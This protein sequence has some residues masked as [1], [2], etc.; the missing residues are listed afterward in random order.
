MAQI[1]VGP[2]SQCPVPIG[3]QVVPEVFGGKHTLF[4]GKPVFAL[5][6]DSHTGFQICFFFFGLF[7]YNVD[8]TRH[9]TRTI[10]NGTRALN[11]LDTFNTVQ[12]DL[13]YIRNPKRG[14]INIYTIHTNLGCVAGH[15]PDV[16]FLS[17]PSIIAAGSPVNARIIGKEFPKGLRRRFFNIHCIDNDD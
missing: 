12:R 13:A 11:D 6:S 10:E 2:K 5:C 1:T 16:D 9:G 4:Q 3:C 17:C 15:A 14:G 7:R 8:G